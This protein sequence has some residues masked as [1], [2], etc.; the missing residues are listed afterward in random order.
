MR[1][2]FHTFGCKLNQYETEALASE[3][4]NRGFSLVPTDQSAEVY[5]VNTCTVTSRSEQKARRLIRKISREH[6]EALL[7]VTG[8]Y[9]QLNPAEIA[10]LGENV[11]VVSQEDKASLLDLPA[12][13]E[14]GGKIETVPVGASKAPSGH[15]DPFRYRVDRFSYHSRAFLKVQ[16]GCDYR[17][18]YCRVPLARGRSLSLD[19][20][21]AVQRAGEIERGGYREI[22]LTGVNL[23]A[24]RWGE[25][26]LPALLSK[27]LAGT[28]VI[29]LRL[30]SLEPEMIKADL[31]DAM[32]DPRVCPHFHLPI[33]SG[34][35]AVL[36]RMRRRYRSD[37]V[38]RA[39]ELLREVKEDPF[40]AADVIVGFPGETEED[41]QASRRLVESLGLSKLHVF[42]FSPRPGT[43]AEH[44]KDPVPER[45][46]D[47]RAG[48]LLRLSDT[49]HERY[50]ERWV[51]RKLEVVLEREGSS[52]E[53]GVWRG[54]SQNY[55]RVLVEGI[56]GQAG[57]MGALV[58]TV[59]DRAGDPCRG[60]F[61]GVL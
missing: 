56:P 42:P 10:S 3:F 31:A 30:S 18:A 41:F 24:Y 61:V 35:D 58:Q 59:I 9:A 36:L 28:R 17:C 14:A 55:L 33:Q 11:H 27:M 32:R 5:I 2:A 22:V 54:L 4:R 25:I 47:R 29:R 48:E 6:P 16:D 45:I 21:L 40:L 44:P 34:S 53:P 19:P 49:L 52:S 15:A 38:R 43:A 60:R 39:V 50:K 26:G 13:F 57:R 1:A 8:C 20:D 23:T 7:V 51:G 37:R 12:V 46:R